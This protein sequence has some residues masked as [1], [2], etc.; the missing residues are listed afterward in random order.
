MGDTEE[1]HGV[2]G[3]ISQ[4]ARLL[5]CRRNEGREVENR[6]IYKAWTEIQEP[7]LDDELPR[8]GQ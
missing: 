2:G 1:C 8:D 3:C 5:E 7:P 4:I 6:A